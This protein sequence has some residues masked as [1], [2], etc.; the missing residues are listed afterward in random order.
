MSEPEVE[1]IAESWP[2]G[3]RFYA[4]RSSMIEASLIN[5][6]NWEFRLQLAILNRLHKGGTFIDGGANIG[7]HACAVARHIGDA[8]N[9]LAIE[10]IPWIADRLE[11]NRELNALNNLTIIRQ[12][13]GSTKGT[14]AIFVPNSGEHNQGRGTFYD[15]LEAFDRQIQVSVVSLDEILAE[16]RCTDVRVIKLDI[17]GAECE[18]LRGARKTLRRW[19]PHIFLEHNHQSWAEA[20]ATLADLRQL[21]CDELGYTL[22]TLPDGNTAVSM[23]EATPP[24]HRPVRW[25]WP[26]RRSLG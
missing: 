19:R 6:R 24:E 1:V 23:I 8:G 25:P 26:R 13:L 12:A 16:T 10:P 15:P 22:Q 4:R 14:R 7:A 9:V 20:G 21:L 11:R 3:A 18:A 2:T 17:E 5:H